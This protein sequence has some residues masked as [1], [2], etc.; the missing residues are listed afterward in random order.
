[1]SDGKSKLILPPGVGRTTAQIAEDAFNHKV[2]LATNIVGNTFERLSVDPAA[3]REALWRLLAC[4]IVGEESA[5]PIG[6][7]I[8][9]AKIELERQMLEANRL[10]SAATPQNDDGASS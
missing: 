1:M 10:L 3:A 6:F 5:A 2:Y 8:A 9:T 7:R 4:D